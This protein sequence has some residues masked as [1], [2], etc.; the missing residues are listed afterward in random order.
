[1]NVYF[2]I[3]TGTVIVLVLIYAIVAHKKRR[4][5][6]LELRRQIREEQRQQELKEKCKSYYNRKR[7]AV[8]A[9]LNANLNENDD[10]EY[11][12]LRAL[13]EERD[14]YDDYIASLDMS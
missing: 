8:N 2:L 10:D 9:N 11:Y 14:A 5:K 12:R 4:A 13:R 1:M 7:V 6:I 3:I